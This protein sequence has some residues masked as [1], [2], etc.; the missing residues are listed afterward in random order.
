MKCPICTGENPREKIFC[1]ECGSRLI[2]TCPRCAVHILEAGKFC[3]E[4]GHD[5]RRSSE[6][7]TDPALQVTGPSKRPS[8][9]PVPTTGEQKHVTVLFSDLSDCTVLSEMLDPEEGQDM[10]RQIVGEIDQVVTKYEG[11]V[12]QLVG[13]TVMAI[14]GVPSAHEDD[15]VRA[16][17]AAR[18]IHGI[19]EKMNHRIAPKIGRS[20]AMHTG[21]Y[22]GLV[23]TASDLKKG[24]HGVPEDTVNFASTLMGL[25]EKGEI[26]VGPDTYRHAE[27][28]FP[29]EQFDPATAI[30]L[31]VLD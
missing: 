2:L 26:L 9:T 30:C 11:S 7:M 31:K 23:G 29:F 19:V 16:I 28:F 5:L 12:E 21:I 25:A 1:R 15:P 4:C 3:G 8:V 22:T 10:M 6:V 13:D 20:L 14:F 18:E 27:G 24:R 17:G